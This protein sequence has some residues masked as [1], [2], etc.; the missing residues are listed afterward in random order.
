VIGRRNVG[1]R[2]LV[3]ALVAAA[4]AGGTATAATSMEVHARLSPVAGTKKAGKFTGVLAQVGS[5]RIT[6]GGT[7]A[8][9][10]LGRWRL[11]WSLSLPG[12]D[13]S[14]TATLRLGAGRGSHVL[15][16]QCSKRTSGTIVLTARQGNGVNK[17]DA[18][19]VVRTRSAKL[20][21]PVKVSTLPPVSKG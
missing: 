3:V 1:T 9:P 20:R 17:G 15:C 8:V 19:V 2:S 11:T 12:L 6:P 21:G 4:I 5:H 16:T 10:Q 7:A 14:M 18:V 13:G